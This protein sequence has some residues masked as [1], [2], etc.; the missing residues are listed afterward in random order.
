MKRNSNRLRLLKLAQQDNSE[1]WQAV[2]TEVTDPSVPAGFGLEGIEESA[3]S[4][5]ALETKINEV[6]E[7]PGTFSA[8][9]AKDLEEMMKDPDLLKTIS[10][11]SDGMDIPD[12][13]KA[14]SKI[15]V[16]KLS[17]PIFAIFFG[18]DS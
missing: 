3:A 18:Y 16:S 6:K 14:A 12:Q 13:A 4:A 8:D 11:L 17:S 15:I 1:A 9:D 5:K 10:D 7:S 2:L